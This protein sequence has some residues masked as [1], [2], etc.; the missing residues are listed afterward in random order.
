[1]VVRSKETSTEQERMA[2]NKRGSGTEMNYRDWE[3]KDATC[4]LCRG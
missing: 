1:V 3:R 2:C 4:M